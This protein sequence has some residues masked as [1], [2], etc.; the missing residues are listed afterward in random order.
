MQQN[1]SLTSCATQGITLSK[2]SPFAVCS[3]TGRGIAGHLA[4]EM[5]SKFNPAISFLVPEHMNI[6]I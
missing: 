3:T 5:E 1:R 4:R 6:H 2:A